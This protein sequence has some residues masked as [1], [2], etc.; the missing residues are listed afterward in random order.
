MDVGDVRSTKAGAST[1][2]TPVSNQSPTSIKTPLNEGRSVNPGYTPRGL[3]VTGRSPGSTKA[4][5]STPA[6]RPLVLWRPRRLS[7]LNEGRSVNPGYTLAVLVCRL[8]RRRWLN[9]GRSVNPG[10]TS[11]G[12]DPRCDTTRWA[13]RRPERQ[14]RLHSTL[15]TCNNL[16]MRGSTKAGASTPATPVTIAGF[17]R[18]DSGRLNEGRSVNPGYTTGGECEFTGDSKA[19]RRPERQPRLHFDPDGDEVRRRAGSTKAGA[20]TPATL[21]IP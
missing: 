18:Q 8:A 9:E 10:Y 19:Q 13:Q 4:G 15:V 1:P 7:R 5:A 17:I 14:P 12:K 6:T 20:S 11:C 16:L 2:A 3:A 21:A